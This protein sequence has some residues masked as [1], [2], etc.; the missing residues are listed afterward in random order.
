MRR[1]ISIFLI[2]C[3]AI[4]VLPGNAWAWPPT[5]S[6]TFVVLMATSVAVIS[7]LIFTTTSHFAG[8]LQ[9]KEGWIK[10]EGTLKESAEIDIPLLSVKKVWIRRDSYIYDSTNWERIIGHVYAGER[11]IIEEEKSDERELGYKLK[12]NP[13]HLIPELNEKTIN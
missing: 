9:K 5:N 4:M 13:D 3:L 7:L 2:I 6:D 10:T 11:Y 8:E 1:L 12:F